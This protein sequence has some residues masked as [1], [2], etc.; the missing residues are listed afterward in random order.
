MSER[1]DH[2]T[3]GAPAA[4]AAAAAGGAP[5]EAGARRRHSDG[6]RW[7]ALAGY[8]RAVRHGSRIA[9]SGT[10]AHEDAAPHGSYAQARSCLERVIAAVEALGGRREDIVRTRIFLAPA[11][12]WEE[13]SRAHAEV[14]GDVAPAN[15]MV[16]V[17]A[18]IGDHLLVE[19]EADAEVAPDADAEAEIDAEAAGE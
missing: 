13:V 7:E 9:V 15:T 2:R 16:T 19:V 14:L 12:D 8:S 1:P 10:T 3:E 11:A 18:L 6:G 5:A 17:A 4:G